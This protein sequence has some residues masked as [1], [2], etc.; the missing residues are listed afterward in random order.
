MKKE[1]IWD[2]GQVLCNSNSRVNYHLSDI[3]KHNQL[4][5]E[6]TWSIFK[7]TH[8]V[9]QNFQERKKLQRE[10]VIV[11]GNLVNQYKNILQKIQALNSVILLV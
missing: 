9:E 4:L 1:L 2:C 5:I 10:N 3:G 8:L 7:Q 11:M 6:Q